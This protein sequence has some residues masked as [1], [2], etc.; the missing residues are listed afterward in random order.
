MGKV[1]S[2]EVEGGHALHVE[3]L[4]AGDSAGPAI[5]LLHGFGASSATWAPLAGDLVATGRRVVAFDRL[6]F[7]A[8]ARPRRPRD[9]W[10]PAG[11]PYRPSLGGRQTL[12]GLDALA[13]HRAVLVAHSAGAVAAVLTAL[14]APDRV[15][16]LGLV[17]P[18]VLTDGPPRLVAASFSVPGAATVAPWVLRRSAGLLAGGLRRTWHDPSRVTADVVERYRAPLR[19]PGWEHALVEMTR[20]VERL[21]L[22]RRLPDVNAPAVVVVGEGD[23]IVR[24]RDGRRVADLLGGPAELVVVPEAGHVVHEEQPAAVAAALVPLVDAARR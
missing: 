5:V 4:G 2:V 8:S 17:A 24:P 6:G 15:A 14:E 13:I 7:G 9:G 3:E 11:S 22:A 21:D 16:A 1:T 20:A 23:R 19:R 10:G 18:A 12:A